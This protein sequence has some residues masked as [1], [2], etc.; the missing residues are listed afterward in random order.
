MSSS[1]KED[2]QWW[3]Q[4]VEGMTCPKCKETGN[5]ET[6]DLYI[7][8]PLSTLHELDNRI[9]NL[10]KAHAILCYTC[11]IEMCMTVGAKMLVGQISD[12]AK[13]IGHRGGDKVLP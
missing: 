5:E 1:N 2:D 11:A 10:K 3:P 4:R 13:K 8:M 9:P 6:G 12:F 7:M